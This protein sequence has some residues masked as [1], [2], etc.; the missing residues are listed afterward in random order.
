[1]KANVKQL[2]AEFST[3]ERHACGLIGVA[4]SSYRYQSQRI[5]DDKLRTKLVELAREQPRF[6]YRRLHVLL[7]RAGECVN[8]KRLWR[9]YKEAGLSVKRRKRKRLTRER[10]EVPM[11]VKAN[12]EWAL[13]FVSDKVASGRS[14]RM[15]TVVDT[16]TREC[17]ALEVDTGFASRRVTGVLDRVLSVR[18][19]PER[20][21]SDNG[22]ELTSRCYLAW[23]IENKIELVHIQP[24]KPMQNGHIESFNGRLR[25]ECLNTSWFRNLQDARRKIGAWRKAYNEVRPHSSLDYRTPAE[26][27]KVAAE[28]TSL[29]S[30]TATGSGSQGNPSGALR[31][32]LTSA[33]APRPD[34][35]QEV[36]SAFC[37]G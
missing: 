31:A 1:M 12:Q 9:I 2:V 36:A 11:T 7:A 4:V 35:L 37:S 3:S 14:I 27:A 29:P 19:K 6:G 26:F 20:I 32:T 17:L 30:I 34:I 15:L 10:K 13:D 28:A 16:F 33:P 8:H 23:G 24:G 18:G 5:P 25:D 21:R 22:P